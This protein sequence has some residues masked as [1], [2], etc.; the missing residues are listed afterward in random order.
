M[1]DSEGLLSGIRVIDCGTYIAGPAAAAVM[2]DFGAEVIK[3]ERPPYGDPGRFLSLLPGAPV[4]KHLYCWILDGRNKKSV[5]LN[6]EH[7]AAREALLKLVAAA[8]VFITNYQAPLLRKFALEYEDLRRVNDRLIY[9]LITGFGEVGAD[10]EK[11]AYDQTAYWG[12]SG[13]MS[14]MHNADAEPC[15]STTGFGDHPTAMT[16]FGGIML[17]LYRRGITGKGMRISTSLMANGAWSNASMI[18]AAM[19]GAQFQPRTTRKT[20]A[21]P[22]VN[23]YLTRDAKRIMVCGL[24]PKKDWSNFCCALGHPEWI[25]DPRFRTPELRRTNSAALVTAIDETLGARDLTDWAEILR[26]H[27]VIWAP[28]LSLAEAAN[29]P[30][31]EENGV[32][33]EIAPGMRTVNNP[34]VVSGTEKVKPRMA[35]E[36][37]EHTL[38]VLRDAGYSEEALA[39]MVRRGAAVA[40]QPQGK[41]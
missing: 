26:Q 16:V 22:L 41:K 28:V 13:L 21:N 15:R 25:E 10:A 30:Q 7:P 20:V 40:G 5:A 32:Y 18:Q 14:T 36:V 31:M 12:R 39:D 9:A 38:E 24:D 4:S 23:H 35:P 34:L 6:L 11:P 27:E 37:G 29:D 17:G 8:D 3:I 33:A 19:V 1:S 2:S